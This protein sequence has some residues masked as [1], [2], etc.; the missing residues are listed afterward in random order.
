MKKRAIAFAIGFCLLFSPVLYAVE[1]GPGLADGQSAYNSNGEEIFL[2][3]LIMECSW[4]NFQDTDFL[5]R[6]VDENINL[7]YG[8]ENTHLWNN[9][10]YWADVPF[11]HMQLLYFYNHNRQELNYIAV[12]NNTGTWHVRHGFGGIQVLED[13]DTYSHRYNTGDAS[14]EMKFFNPFQMGD[15][16]DNDMQY[17]FFD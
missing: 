6:L 10:L 8:N 16:D 2:C 5:D 12:Y 13:G 3:M 11:G 9:S 7:R 4:E 1:R 17:G 14:I 15:W